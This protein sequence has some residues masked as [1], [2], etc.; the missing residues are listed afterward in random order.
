MIGAIRPIFSS[1]K[2]KESTCSLVLWIQQQHPQTVGLSRP[3]PFLDSFLKLFCICN[4]E[5]SLIM[6]L[7][8]IHP[9]AALLDM[10]AGDL[11]A[12]QFLATYQLEPV[13][14]PFLGQP[15]DALL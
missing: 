10:P 1:K 15:G 5:C 4:L 6:V 14:H 9:A 3:D 12:S 7:I 2:F 11:A 13:L 8:Q